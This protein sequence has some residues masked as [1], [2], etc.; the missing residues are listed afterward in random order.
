VTAPV[1]ASVHVRRPPEVAFRVFTDRIGDWWPLSTHSCFEEKAAGVRLAADRLVERSLD[2]EEEVWGEVLAWDPPRHFA[3]TWHPGR[4]GGPRSVVEVD[5]RPDQD[6]TRVEV[7][8]SGW[9]AFGP[10]A[11]RRRQSYD[12][13]DGWSAVLDRYAQFAAAG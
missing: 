4:P 11:E 2:G 1:L 7:T 12:R 8:H 6:G 5:F 3:V 10:E 9:E 13:P